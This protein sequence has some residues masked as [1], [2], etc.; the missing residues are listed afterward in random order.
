MPNKLLIAVLLSLCLAPGMAAAPDGDDVKQYLPQAR[1]K[2]KAWQPDA[3]LAYLTIGSSV[4]ADGS[5][6]CTPEHPSTGWNYAFYSKAADGY[7][8]VYGCKGQVTA[9]PTGKGAKPAPP[10]ISQD[11]LGT[12]EV[13]R[14]LK[15]VS[16]GWGLSRCQS[17]QALRPDETTGTPVWSTMLDCG[18]VGATVV[19]DAVSGKVLKSRRTS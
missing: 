17:V 12:P 15:D 18:D 16:H 1:E 5:N 10:A 2:A 13:L 7:Y 14:I 3:E 8:T 9:E 6:A 11:F 19:I 4:Q